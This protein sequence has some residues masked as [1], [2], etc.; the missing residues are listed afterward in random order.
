MKLRNK[1]ILSCAALAAVATTA[2][3]TTFAW[4]TANDT[5]KAS[6]IT[7]KTSEDDATLL[8]ISETGLQSSWGAKVTI[9]SSAVTLDPVAYNATDKAYYPWDPQANE[10]AATASSGGLTTD[11][12]YISFY[13][14]FKSGSSQSLDVVIDS[15]ALINTTGGGTSTVAPTLPTF[16]VLADGTGVTANSYSVNMFRALNVVLTVEGGT[17]VAKNGTTPT[18]TAAATRTVYN[19]DALASGDNIVVNSANAHTYYNN[20]K[21]LD[22]GIDDDKVASESSTSIETLQ[23]GAFKFAVPTGAGAQAASGALDNILM[24]RF[25][26]YLD[27]WD[28]MCFDACRK[29]TF[30][31]DMEFSATAHAG[32]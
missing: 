1:L 11:D 31:L 5:V 29:Q 3:S 21:S 10:E 4:Y 22:P 23:T 9:D 27:G 18:C 32:A 14:Y 13:L 12:D 2:F 30:S 19:C 15:F 24:V 8:L 16:S 7:G 28:K 26:I 17:E 25:D 20:V 6:G